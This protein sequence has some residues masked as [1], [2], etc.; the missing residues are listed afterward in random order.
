MTS[1]LPV[2]DLK[3]AKP[4]DRP[5]LLPQARP[6]GI[7]REGLKYEQ[8]LAK[9]W[10]QAQHSLWFEYQDA[11]GHH[12]CQPDFVQPSG[13]VVYVMEA[14]RTWVS[15]AHV[16]LE[17]LYCP[18]V[19]KALN[20]RALP[21]VVCKNLSPRLDSDVL[22]TTDVWQAQ[23]MAGL[24]VRGRGPRVVLHWIGATALAPAA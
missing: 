19:S 13:G 16:K 5:R 24:R 3:W 12:Y 7:K 10:P 14:K 11:L 23:F 8:L 1:W 17:A 4:C 2:H 6:R 15:E 20:C 9:Q 22:V 21:I 18:V